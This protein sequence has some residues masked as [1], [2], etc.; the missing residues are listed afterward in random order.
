MSKNTSYLI[1]LAMLAAACGGTHP[2]ASPSDASAAGADASAAC[3]NACT[4]GATR[5]Q[6]AEEQ[7]CVSIQGC[8]VWSDPTA[9]ASGSTCMNGG[10]VAQKMCACTPGAKRCVA[11]G[12]ESC[13]DSGG[14]CGAWGNATA[15]PQGAMCSGSGDCIP[16]SGTSG[17]YS[18][19]SFDVGGETRHYWLHVPD[20][21]ACADA[22][23]LV[24]DF[25]G[26]AVTT[27]DQTP[28][29]FYGT[30]ELVQVANAEKFI[31]VRPR[32]RSMMFDA[33]NYL[34]Q[35]DV[36]AG[37]LEKN[38]EMAHRLVP[39]IAS[40]YHIDPARTYATGF[41]NGTNMSVQ[42]LAD[43][44]VVFHGTGLMEGGLWSTV[45]PSPFA[46]DAPRIYATTGWRDYIHDTLEVF[47][48]F[49]Q[50]HHFPNDRLWLRETD[51]GHE[52]YG[53]QFREAY[54][55]ID[56][57]EQPAQGQLS[58]PWTRETFPEQ[59]SLLKLVPGRSGDILAGSTG[60]KLWRRDPMG[61]WT[62]TATLAEQ[63]RRVAFTSLCVLPSGQGAAVGQGALALT[64]D[65]GLHWTLGPRVP[66]L[67]GMN[68][69]YSYLVSVACSASQIV[70][71]GYW[72]AVVTTDAGMHWT[73]ASMPEAFSTTSQVAAVTRS[74]AGTWL[75]LGYYDYLGRSTDGVSF[76]AIN[77]PVQPQWLTAAAS[78]PQGR[79]WAVGEEGT[80]IASIDDGQTFN[81]QTSST[82][83]D[84]YGIAF[85][86]G[87]HGL[88]V[89]NHGAA[90]Y[91]ADGGSTW[92]PVP[93]GLD[94]YLGDVTWLDPTTA[95][96]AGEKGT[97][98]R[99]TRP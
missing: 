26:T 66:E 10:C 31:V 58:P 30:D 50:V 5:C 73:Q 65:F 46:M 42:F 17:T 60:G 79:W 55:W 57:G 27:L 95:L 75:A 51:S 19:Q 2:P 11:A 16:C 35:W 89:G 62:R 47:E 12:V 34:F 61:Q 44:P 86:D 15:C 9:C 96:V 36:N 76:T 4:E 72:A 53:W 84:L 45:S 67:S 33:Q 40:A 82:T 92:S 20:S 68:F 3:M 29:E 48:A 38:V 21:Y 90:I 8:T 64:S 37:D 1:P 56:R 93:T 69:G 22:W 77:T 6:G 49:L 78:A 23:P 97:L 14:G 41:S 43:Q 91:T 13:D 63:G 52:V 7:L 59:E 70:G 83:E 87:M 98:L 25:H 28:E 32:S 71:G 80:V 94:V 74:A 81:A 88:A 24:V 99:F 39:L 85:A 54:R 18:N